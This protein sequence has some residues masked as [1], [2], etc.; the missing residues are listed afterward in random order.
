MFP[1]WEITSFLCILLEG[2]CK[3][4]HINIGKD[5]QTP[6]YMPLSFSHPFSLPFLLLFIF[7]FYSAFVLLVYSLMFILFLSVLMFLLMTVLIICKCS[8][9]FVYSESICTNITWAM[10]IHVRKMTFFLKNRVARWEDNY[11]RCCWIILHRDTWPPFHSSSVSIILA[12]WV[13]DMALW[14][15]PI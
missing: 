14:F 15:L 3:N 2:P 5:P 9:F 1:S 13:C 4:V 8:L 12:R 7:Y 6:L 10:W 11:E